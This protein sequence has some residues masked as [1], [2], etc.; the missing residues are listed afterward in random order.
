MM[1]KF[2]ERSQGALVFVGL[3]VLVAVV[4]MLMMAGNQR[5]MQ[6]GA[7]VIGDAVG[8]VI[9]N[10][11]AETYFA[12]KGTQ[13][14]YPNK[15]A[16]KNHAADAWTTVDCYNRNGAFHVM[17]NAAGD[18]NLLC[19]DD[20][21]TVRDVILKRRGNSN[22]FDFKNAYTPKDGTFKAIKYWLENTW[23]CSKGSMPKDAVIVIDNVIP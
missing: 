8:E 2:S 13:T 15:H 23:K 10:A 5:N 6:A 18:F 4:L 19:R 9:D 12:W 3:A 1:K 17:S 16:I 14:L 11:A 21:G 20:D 7:E 22:I